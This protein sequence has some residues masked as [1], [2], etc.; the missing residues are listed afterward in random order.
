MRS[1]GG[2]DGNTDMLVGKSIGWVELVDIK[3]SSCYKTTCCSEVRAWNFDFGVA[4]LGPNEAIG[5]EGQKKEDL[6]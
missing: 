4:A 6:W 3:E 1:C 2:K 5:D